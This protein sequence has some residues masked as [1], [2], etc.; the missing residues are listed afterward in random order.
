MLKTVGRQDEGDRRLS[1]GDRASIRRSAR[2][3][4]ASP[5]SRRSSS[6]RPTSRRWSR[7]LERADLKDDDRFHLEFALGKA[8]HDARPD[9]TRR[10]PIMRRAMRCGASTTPSA[11]TTSTRAGRS[12]HRAVHRARLLTRPGGMRR[13]RPDLHRRHAARGIDPGRANPV[14]AQP[15]RG[16]VGASRHAGDRARTR[17]IIRPRRSS[18]TADERARLRRGISEAQRGPAPDRPAVL[19]RQAAQQ[20]DV[21]AV[22]PA[23]PAQREDHRCAPPSARLLLV[24]LPPAFRARAGLHLRPRPISAAIIPIMCG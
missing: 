15:G 12:Q 1:Q 9:A 21:R 16:H 5:T 10:S 18:L 20:L 3:G 23:G 24:Q 2:P 22:H 17:Q 6:T 7:L 4:G 8:M 19:H 14:V 11:R 13:A